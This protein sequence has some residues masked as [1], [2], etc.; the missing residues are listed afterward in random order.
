[1]KKLIYITGLFTF[2]LITTFSVAAIVPDGIRIISN[3]QNGITLSFSPRGWQQT[4]KKY[5]R[6]LFDFITFDGAEIIG[7]PGEPQIPVASV[8]IGIPLQGNANVEIVDSEFTEEKAFLAPVPYVYRE[9][10]SVNYVYHPNDSLYATRTLFPQKPVQLALPGFFRDQR[11]VR[12][13]FSPLQFSPELQE[14]KK[15]S[16]LV[17]HVSLPDSRDYNANRILTRS[18]EDIYR[19]LIINYQQAKR[20]R[21]ARDKTLAKRGTGFDGNV[22][23]QVKINKEGIYRI[24]GQTLLNSGIELQSVNPANIKMYN[25]GGLELPRSVMES[26]PDSPTENA[27]YVSDGDDGK[28]DADDFILFYG[29]G[30]DGWKYDRAGKKFQHYINHYNYDDIYFLCLGNSPGKRMELVNSRSDVEQNPELFFTDNT[31][32]EEEL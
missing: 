18:D 3:D 30:I 9:N 24:T 31:F 8:L 16:R 2:L 19:S 20:W 1:M 23:Y 13:I 29:R 27:I 15:Y 10:D 22:L 26:R 28:F 12:L 14:V 17:V 5:N 6:T 32:N 4:H 25:N 11:V 21:K 7:A